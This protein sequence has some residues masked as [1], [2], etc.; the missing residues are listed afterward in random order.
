MRGSMKKSLVEIFAKHAGNVSDKWEHYLSV[1]ERELHF[2]ASQ[3]TPLRLL[4]IG[5]QNGGSLQIWREYLPV[6][7]HIVGV[8]IDPL[9]RSLE[10]GANV[11]LHV[12]DATDRTESLRFLGDSSYDLIVDDG[13][14]VSADIIKTFEHLFSRLVAGGIYF[15][16]DTHCSY[17]ASHGGGFQSRDTAIEYFKRIIDGINADHFEKDVEAAVPQ[18]VLTRLHD[19]R[20]AIESISFYDSMIVIRKSNPGRV[21]PFRRTL[22]GSIAPVQDIQNHL[23]LVPLDQLR[24]LLLTSSAAGYLAPAM[25]ENLARSKERAGRLKEIIEGLQPALTAANAAMVGADLHASRQQ[26]DELKKAVSELNLKSNELQAELNSSKLKG[27]EAVAE[28][29]FFKVQADELKVVRQSL[30]LTQAELQSSELQ[31]AQINEANEELVSELNRA[32]VNEIFLEESVSNLRGQCAKDEITRE[33]LKIEMEGLRSERETLEQ[34][35]GELE[36]QLSDFGVRTSLAESENLSLNRALTELNHALT[37]ALG[38]ADEARIKVA[39]SETNIR[40]LQESTFWKASRPF[41]AI[42]GKSP[43]W[44]RQTGRRGLMAFWWTITGQLL[45]RLRQRGAA[46]HNTAEIDAYSPPSS[47]PV[48]T[49]ILP[50]AADGAVDRPR[51]T[52]ADEY[53]NWCASVEPDKETLE[54]QRRL[55]LNFSLQPKFSVLVPVFRTPV[56]VFSEMVASVLCQTYHN[57]ELCLAIVDEGEATVNLV[58]EA[59][60]LAKCDPRVRIQLLQTNLGISGNT[61]EAL[62]IAIGEWAVLLDHDDLLTPDALFELAKAV[63]A[64][65]T[66]GFIYSDKDSIDRYAEKRFGPLFKPT[67]SPEIMLN[68]NYL[69]HLTAMKVSTVRAIGGWDSATDG[70]QDWDIFLRVIAEERVII[71]VPRVL[72]HWRWIETSV[73]VGGLDA[74]PY[75][76]AGQ[77]RTLEKYLN[78]TGWPGAKADMDGPYLRIKWVA[79]VRQTVSIVLIGEVTQSCLSPSKDFEILV[80]DG[81]DIAAAVDGAISNATGDIIVL[82]D[83]SFTAIDPLSIEEL[84]QP[85]SN[86]TIA[87]VAGRV[88]DGRG[89]VVDYGVF[90]QGGRA[91]PAFRRESK[92]YYGA[93]GGVGWYRN[94]SAAAGG[95]LGFRRSVWR[96]IGGLAQWPNLERPDLAFCLEVI[97]RGYGRLMLNPFAHFVSEGVSLFELQSKAPISP[98]LVWRALPKGDPYLNPWLVADDAG[99]PKIQAPVVHTGTM[100]K[101]HDFFGEARYVASAFDATKKQVEESINDCARHPVGPIKRVIWIIPDFNVAFYGGINTILRTAEYMRVT[102]G[103][104]PTFAVDGQASAPIIRARIA[105]AFPA[106]ADACDV[107]ILV[108]SAPALD[109]G[110]A[111]TAVCTLWTTAY[112][113]L[114]LRNVR[115][116]FYFVQDWEPL[117]YPSGT[118]STFVEATYR[119]GF[120]GICNTRSLA[121]SYKNL[122]GDAGYFLPAVDTSIFHARTRK[123]RSPNDPFV[124]VCYTRPGT[125]RNCFEA[126]SEAMRMLKMRYGSDLEIITA[127]AEW[128]PAHYGLDGVVRN[129]GLLPYH[130]TATLYRASDAGLV[131]MATRHPS[132]LPFE[133]MACGAAVVTNRNSYTSWL[134]RDGENCLLC[135]MNRTDVFDTVSRLIESRE[136]RDSIA[137]KAIADIG[138]NHSSW[139]D[140]CSQIYSLMQNVAQF[141]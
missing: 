124:L 13:S 93:A 48:R 101:A 99:A 95:A 15:I 67:W 84:V 66:V 28:V 72:Y 140:S 21:L 11:E 127:G 20:R 12:F 53:S 78:A 94:A 128:N 82:L 51:L 46:V 31:K 10:L 139:S 35:L 50:I 106:L 3:E 114:R 100:P 68:A 64:E 38:I 131:A 8:D 90:F 69:T 4:E 76:L 52:T 122:G 81:A 59:F 107:V 92:D 19:I 71:H 105:Q 36:V 133:W 73:S 98:S 45:R 79:S 23:H 37:E 47:G 137:A 18:E 91:F 26:T 41:R 87:L 103:V 60:K 117:F 63:N 85:L 43:T 25:L 33:N 44:V 89:N 135:E 70:A 54:L 141:E 74:K 61:N 6:G 111:D 120:Y 123:Q 58:E 39:S 138:A 110:V 80:A 97:R 86:P 14:H 65:P 88:T 129:L 32:N 130:E 96:E 40:A 16:E 126:L 136:L 112:A 77:I 75:A 1:Y 132:Y 2:L 121:E 83:A 134:L 5:V 30:E 104:S 108:P 56:D 102:H 62:S 125:P 24:T 17:Y 57:W 49:S 115:R 29:A 42:L 113:L 9:V 55:S 7:S 116:K 109:L 119:F 27:E 118:L 34:R 22:T